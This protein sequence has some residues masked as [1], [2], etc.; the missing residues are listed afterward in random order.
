MGYIVVMT[1]YAHN[2]DV[3]EEYI[4]LCPILDH[5]HMD[6]DSFLA[7]IKNVEVKYD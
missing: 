6:R 3:I 4:D 1:K 5:L 2:E 7:P